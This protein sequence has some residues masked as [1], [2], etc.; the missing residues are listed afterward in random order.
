MYDFPPLVAKIAILVCLYLFLFAAYRELYRTVR[1]TRPSRPS[2]AWAPSDSRVQ[3]ALVVIGAG[4]SSSA[5]LGE[6]IPLLTVNTLGRALDNTLGI[7][8]TLV[9]KHHARIEYGDGHFAVT[10]VG[11]TNGTFVNERP[12]SAPTVL[13][14]GDRIRLGSTVFEFRV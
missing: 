9:S 11:S 1:A 10:D 3:P 4:E 2:T 5:R 12:V 6:A 13:R 7:A 14:V 8:D